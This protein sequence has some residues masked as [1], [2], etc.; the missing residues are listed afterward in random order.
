MNIFRNEPKKMKTKKRANNSQYIRA[1]IHGWKNLSVKIIMS[2]IL[3]M[4][5]NKTKNEQHTQ[6]HTFI[7]LYKKCVWK[8]LCKQEN[9]LML[10]FGHALRYICQRLHLGI[11]NMYVHAQ[12]VYC[13]KQIHSHSNNNE[14]A[15]KTR[16]R[17]KTTGWEKC[18][19]WM[20]IY[21]YI[22]R[23]NNKNYN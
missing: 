1:T 17:K 5:R 14:W 16:E 10:M 11:G 23:N 13:Q 4:G 15:M 19:D 6:T 9:M 18:V 2:V 8:T 21:I 12:C 3:C 22:F 20:A 7:L